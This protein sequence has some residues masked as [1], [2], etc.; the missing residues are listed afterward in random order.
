LP[1]SAEFGSDPTR[2]VR[3]RVKK[4]KKKKTKKKKTK[5][6]R[7]AQIPLSASLSNQHGTT[8]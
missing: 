3:A 4:K 1:S 7:S 5:K 2:T 8:I 6:K